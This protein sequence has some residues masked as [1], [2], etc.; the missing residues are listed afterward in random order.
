MIVI[1]AQNRGLT[2]STDYCHYPGTQE[3]CSRNFEN[4]DAKSNYWTTRGPCHVIVPFDH[5]FR[6]IFGETSK[7][8]NRVM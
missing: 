7:N 1:L 5:R 2:R 6:V 8:Y 4:D 3:T